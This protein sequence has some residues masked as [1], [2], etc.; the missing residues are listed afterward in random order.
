MERFDYYFLTAFECCWADADAGT[1]PKELVGAATELAML[2]MQIAD[3]KKLA[4]RPD[5]VVKSDPWGETGA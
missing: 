2:L 4:L 3:L 5:E 1:D